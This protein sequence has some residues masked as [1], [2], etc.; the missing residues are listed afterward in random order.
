MDDD[1]HGITVGF[2]LLLLCHLLCFLIHIL[3]DYL[4]Y[5]S[6]K[7]VIEIKA[8]RDNNPL[9]MY[10]RHTTNL[11]SS[12]SMDD[13]GVELYDDDD[14]EKKE[15]QPI[16]AAENEDDGGE[17]PEYK[18]FSHTFLRKS[19]MLLKVAIYFFFIIRS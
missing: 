14:E 1:K 8:E 7:K 5:L 9:N 17:H 11:N 13:L 16:E 6:Y 18:I 10:K 19:L 2:W 4:G 3:S 15:G 12:A